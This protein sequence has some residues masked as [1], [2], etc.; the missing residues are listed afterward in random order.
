MMEYNA[1]RPTNNEGI[2]ED[3]R[4]PL[5]AGSEIISTSGICYK[6]KKDA[7]AFGG[8]ALIYR[9]SREG[10]L[11][12]FILKEFYP[13]SKKFNF[14][15]EGVIIRSSD[16]TE[17]DKY[18]RLLKEN[19]VRENT[20]GQLLANKTGRTIS[21]LENLN[22][23]KIIVNGKSF[24]AVGSYF[25]VLEEV[26][27]DENNRGWFLKDLLEECAKPV[28]DDAPL[29]TGGLPS[30]QVA[31]CIIE[32]LLKALRDVHKAGYVHGDINDANFFLTSPDAKNGDIGVGQLLDFGNAF[33]IEDDGKT[34]PVEN[35]FSTSGYWS[36]EILNSNG[37]LQLT[38]A[39]DVYSAG[40]LMLYLL[41]GMRY[42]KVYGKNL[43]K[44]FS[45][46]TFVPM[47][48]VMQCGYRREAAILFVKILS[49]ALCYNHEKRYK[50][51]GEMLKDIIFLKKIIAPPK[52][53]LS[54]NLS[55][56]PYFVK[57]SRDREIDRLQADMDKGIQP[58][59]IWGIGGI[60]K[61]ELVMEF[62]RKQIEKG[63]SAYLVT[64]RETIKETILSM[65][66][67]GWRF[68]FDGQ[69]DALN[70]EYQARLDLLKENYKDALLI[71]DNFD[72]D[73][74]TLSELMREPAYKELIGLDMKILFTTRSRPNNSVPELE[75][76]SEE[77]A[78][79]LFNSIAKYS[80]KEETFVRK[81]I[82]EVDFHPMTVEI[83]AHTL[84]ESW[85]T[86]TV[87]DLLKC[88]RT[89]DLNSLNLPE[90]KHKKVTNEREA[91]IY[92]HLQTLFN[93]FNAED[94]YREILCHTTLL[95]VDGFDAAE[96]ILSEDNTKKKQLKQLEGRGWIRRRAEDNFLYI[97]PLIRS[98]FKNKIQ[99]TNADC[100]KFLSTLWQRLDDRYPQEKKLFRQAAELYER[101]AID[102]GDENGEHHFHA[103]YC[104]IVGENFAK[105]L[106]MEER[107]VQLR[108]AIAD[109]TNIDLARTYNDAGAAAGYAQDYVK[110]MIFFDK[111][112]KFLEANA[113]EDPNTANILS[114][115]AN[116]YLFL[117]D[118]DKAVTLGERAVKIFEKTPPKNKHEQANAYS[119]YGNTLLWTKRFTEAEPNFFAAAKILEELTPEGSQELAKV[120]ID[121]GQ[122]YLFFED[123]SPGEI[124][125]LKGLDI[126]EKL[127]PKNHLDKMITC[128][129][130]SKIY[131]RIGNLEENKKFT[132]MA[133]K[134]RKGNIYQE[135]KELLEL[136]LDAIELRADKMSTDEF[137]KCYRTVASAYRKIG[138]LEQAQ[139]F[140]LSALEKITNTTAAAE[141]YLT[142]FEASELFSDKKEFDTAVSYAKKGLSILQES[143][144]DN[145]SSLSKHAMKLGI[146]CNGTFDK[147]EEALEYFESAIQFQLK[148]PY[149][150]FD[151][152]RFYQKAIGI[153]LKGLKRFDEAQTVFEKILEGLQQIFPDSHPE[154][155]EIHDLL[156]EV[157][158]LKSESD[159]SFNRGKI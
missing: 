139:K 97:H 154:I 29:R 152:I 33:K 39:T 141:M 159:T 123:S 102:L 15:R 87:K 38:Q 113:P 109:K 158:L 63:R 40:C 155:K 142:Y 137:I 18:F 124:C 82:R 146:L 138:K 117:G 85:G 129:V 31:T 19:M 149:P 126:Q 84:N 20:I 122:L 144:P 68:E 151:F 110:A 135:S 79:S 59:W 127:L 75:S 13:Y 89:E 121:L 133:E 57:G 118:Y 74:K 70:S 105:A 107:A 34:L 150:D 48:K 71:V 35:V 9:V 49:K 81:L 17:A 90:I 112:I 93:L 54:A 43:A 91:K 77:N 46:A 55:R 56:S 21:A 50:D 41:K 76:L 96:F 26:T 37:G 148:S 120:Y 53:N 78:L 140:I 104:H 92:G 51:A 94:F 119:I 3:G 157:R 27:S 73:I 45:V 61:T 72:S 1:P 136:T 8:S 65:N 5:P 88:L 83:L 143:E 103:G 108:E 106:A 101:A 14:V 36:P 114:N 62:A 86:L 66:F 95:P 44:N 30:P 4:T 125:L 25:I 47:K 116:G 132:D 28:Q 131:R 134:I 10:S 16:G 6:I 69:G 2:L 80:S 67:S 32:E 147:V 11:R 52:F 130:L 12:N 24:E 153:T 42:K 64:F 60:G 23:E 156:D 115:I 128:K 99:P 7:V 58:L 98:V 22:V 100:N 145:F 111:A